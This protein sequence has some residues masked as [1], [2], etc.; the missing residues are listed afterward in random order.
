MIT[1]SVSYKA[2]DG[3][4]IRLQQGDA[5]IRIAAKAARIPPGAGLASLAY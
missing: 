5:I 2:V 3:Y 4:N 1:I